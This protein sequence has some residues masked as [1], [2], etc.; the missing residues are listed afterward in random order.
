[1]SSSLR[2]RVHGGALFVQREHDLERFF[3]P[4]P[5]GSLESCVSIV[6]P[7]VASD[8]RIHECL[9][10]LDAL[11]SITPPGMCASCGDPAPCGLLCNWCA[12]AIRRGPP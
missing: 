9:R 2:F 7:A 4:A 8:E 12:G 1:M 5:K 11:L 3:G 10:A 6:T